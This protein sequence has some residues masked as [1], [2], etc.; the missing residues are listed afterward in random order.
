MIN[1]HAIT[2]SIAY[3]R[4]ADLERQAQRAR[5]ARSRIVRGN[6][7]TGTCIRSM[8][9]RVLRNSWGAGSNRS[10]PQPLR[11]PG[12][13]MGSLGRDILVDGSVYVEVWDDQTAD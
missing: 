1:H 8:A 12:R 6:S 11:N 3:Q 4:R 10:E 9:T 7:P 13:F 5:L 2:S